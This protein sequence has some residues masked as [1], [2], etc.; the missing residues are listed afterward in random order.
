MGVE[1]YRVRASRLVK[2]LS[3]RHGLN[4]TT[5]DGLTAIAAEEGIPR[6]DWNA[7][8]ARAKTEPYENQSELVIGTPGCGKSHYAK[9]EV[10]NAV[11]V[12]RPTLI[13]SMRGDYEQLVEALGGTIHTVRSDGVVEVKPGHPGLVLFT[14]DGL[15]SPE[16]SAK[17]TWKS[18]GFQKPALKEIL[19]VLDE[20]YRYAD[21]GWLLDLIQQIA[22]HE[23]ATT[24]VV[25]QMPC[26]AN[27]VAALARVRRA[28]I[29]RS[30][31][32][33]TRDRFRADTVGLVENLRVGGSM[34]RR[35]RFLTPDSDITTLSEKNPD[36]AEALLRTAG[37]RIELEEEQPPK[38][39]MT[40]PGDI[41]GIG[42]DASHSSETA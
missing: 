25:A 10:V 6:A 28:R 23:R 13:V 3:S 14:W 37:I 27:R 16:M 1:A 22:G 35:I 42:I 12:E 20:V 36:K 26:D 33:V 7:L 32:V 5:S 41:E 34:I 24:L 29:F 40:L 15:R 8:A 38:I 31:E 21:D 17:P 2:Y 9:M 4:L 19:I 11:S 18:L 30:P 39:R